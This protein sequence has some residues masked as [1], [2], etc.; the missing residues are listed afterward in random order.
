MLVKLIIAIVIIYV[1]VKLIKFIGKKVIFIILLLGLAFLA[2]S[3][4]PTKNLK[5]FDT[6]LIST[7]IK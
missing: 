6:N 4:E 5:T 1:F 7:T 2:L 3:Q